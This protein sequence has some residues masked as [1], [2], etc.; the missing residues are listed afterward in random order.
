MSV[1]LIISGKLHLMNV[2][3]VIQQ[4][5]ILKQGLAIGQGKISDLATQNRHLMEIQVSLYSV[6]VGQNQ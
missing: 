1:L 5:V 4:A 2:L 6:G 3:G